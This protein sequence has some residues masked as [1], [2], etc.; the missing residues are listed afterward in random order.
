MVAHGAPSCQP[1]RQTNMQIGFVFMKH[2]EDLD[3]DHQQESRF[4]IKEVVHLS[5]L[6]WSA[7]ILT[8]GYLNIIKADPTFVASIFTGCLANYGIS[9]TDN[10][11]GGRKQNKNTATDKTTKPTASPKR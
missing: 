4:G 7:T 8:A 2:D 5:V 1:K 3:D 6:A 10:S 11:S 9:R